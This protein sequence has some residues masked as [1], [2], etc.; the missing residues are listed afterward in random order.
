MNVYFGTTDTSGEGGSTASVLSSSVFDML[1]SQKS[2][3]ELQAEVSIH[4]SHVGNVPNTES[5][6]YR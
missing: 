6:V 5:V 3:I 2:S 1:C 4:H